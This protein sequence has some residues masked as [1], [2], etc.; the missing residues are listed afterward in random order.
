[1]LHRSIG[2]LLCSVVLLCPSPAQAATATAPI[3]EVPAAGQGGF[4]VLKPT[5]KSRELRKLASELH[6]NELLEELAK[7]LNDT[8]VLPVQVG[9]RLM[10]CDESNAYYDPEIR[11][12]QMCLELID[13]MAEILRPQFEDD[14]DFTDALAGAF[15]ATALHE[16]GHALVD[17]LELPITG[18]EEDAVDQLSAWMLI[19][20]GDSGSVLG[21]AAAYYT[22]YDPDEEDFSGEHSLD[23]QRYF[24]LVC[25]VYGSSPD[26]NEELINDWELPEGRAERCEA[27]YRLVDRSWKHLLRDHLRPQRP[28]PG[29]ANPT[30]RAEPV[31]QTAEPVMQTAPHAAPE[32][33]PNAA[34]ASTQPKLIGTS[35]PQGRRDR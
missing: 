35:K 10:Q 3:R 26:D 13:G 5:V 6:R 7:Y 23:R 27:E 31:I 1:M 32:A 9:M 19:E 29:P 12:I 30:R 20:A 4:V 34:P 15:I 33:K 18:R 17:V 11:E 22:E 24:N 2:A 25:W 16:V 14:E 28:T 8:F 21:A